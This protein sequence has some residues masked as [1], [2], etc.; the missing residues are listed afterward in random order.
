LPS[1]TKDV[2]TLQSYEDI[3]GFKRA[4]LIVSHLISSF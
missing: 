4:T 3:C 2:D 1:F